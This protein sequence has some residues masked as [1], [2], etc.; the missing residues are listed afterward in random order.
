M[1]EMTPLAL[2]ELFFGIGCVLAFAYCV[3]LFASVMGSAKRTGRSAPKPNGPRLQPALHL[4]A[5]LHKSCHP[6]DQ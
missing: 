2:A 1:H 6:I 3:Y 4:N 5:E